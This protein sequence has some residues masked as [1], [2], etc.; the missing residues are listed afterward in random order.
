MSGR[1][2]AEGFPTSRWAIG[3][4]PASQNL[5]RLYEYVANAIAQADAGLLNSAI[6]VLGTLRD[7]FRG[8]RAEAAQLE[9]AGAIPPITPPRAVLATG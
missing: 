5:V 2:N 4:D 1:G 7:G 3:G 6:R 8:I 9:R